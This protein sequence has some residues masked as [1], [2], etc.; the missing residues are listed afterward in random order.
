[1]QGLS[2]VFK[3]TAGVWG[4]TQLLAASNGAARD[5][6]GSAIALQ[7][8]TALIGAFG[9]TISGHETQGAA[10]V[11]TETNNV[12]SQT[13]FLTAFNGAAHDS[14]GTSVAVFNPLQGGTGNG[15]VFVIGAPGVFDATKPYS[16]AAYILGEQ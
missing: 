1:L 5:L 3:P 6:F 7:N 16:G 15:P 2:Y 14:F 13:A 4:Q 12:F 10:Y 9:R 8:G 11:F